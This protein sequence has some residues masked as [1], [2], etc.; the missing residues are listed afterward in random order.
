MY[1]IVRHSLWYT[2]WVMGPRSR[3][4]VSR[5]PVATPDRAVD[6]HGSPST[7][8]SVAFSVT[9]PVIPL[10]AHLCSDHCPFIFN[11]RRAAANLTRPRRTPARWAGVAG[12]GPKPRHGRVHWCRQGDVVTPFRP[13]RCV[14]HGHGMLVSCQGAQD[15]RT[16]ASAGTHAAVSTMYATRLVPRVPSSIFRKA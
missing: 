11:A 10:L 7:P 14:P 9:M 5:V 3:L 6:P 4:V 1:T 12:C 16:V 15:A 13:G 8:L 2:S